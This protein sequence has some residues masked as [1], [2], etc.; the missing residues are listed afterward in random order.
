L[1]FKKYEG[2]IDIRRIL[3]KKPLVILFF[4]LEIAKAKKSKNEGRD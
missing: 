3:G 2:T 4:Y 1:D